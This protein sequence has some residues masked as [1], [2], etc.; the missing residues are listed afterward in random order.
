M[1]GVTEEGAKVT[2]VYRQ[3][4]DGS[5][6]FS[7]AT[8][9]LKNASD[10]IK[11]LKTQYSIIATAQ[12]E[13]VTALKSGNETLQANYKRDIDAANEKVDAIK[14]EAQAAKLSQEAQENIHRMSLQAIDSELKFRDAVQATT[15]AIQKKN[16]A[17]AQKNQN[18]LD[19]HYIKE[20][21]DAYK[22]LSTAQSEYEKAAASK[23]SS[24]MSYWKEEADKARQVADQ[25][26]R[27]A[28]ATNLSAAAKEKIR[29]I[30][31]DLNAKAEEHR[32]K[33]QDIH[34]QLE[35]NAVSLTKQVER[36]LATMVIMRGLK[37]IWNDAVKY[38]RTY[39]DQ[40]NEIRIVT[41]MNQDEADELGDSYR[42]LAQEMS[43]TSTEV[44]KAAVEFW[45]QG[46][47]KQQV[48]ER[49][50]YTTV[51][52]KISALDFETAAE[53]MTAATNSMGMSADRVADVWAYLGDAS[54]SGADE[55]GTAMQKVSAS[56]QEAGISFEWLGAY[57]A[58]LSEKTR[59]AP[60]VIGTALNSM[61]SRLQQ[62]KQKGYN[63][64]DD[65]G[66][67]DISKA[68]KTIKVELM[69]DGEWRSVSDVLDDIAAKWG[70]L[71]DKTK[72]YI[73]TVMGGT[74]QRNYLL[75][76][77]NDMSKGAENGSRA[78]ELYAGAQEAAGVAMEKYAIWEESVEAAQNRLTAA[79]EQLYS[80]LSGEMIKGWYDTLAWIINGINTASEA[81]DGWN[82]K[83]ALLGGALALLVL[84]IKKVTAATGAATFSA[85]T[86][87]YVMTGITT[88]ATGAT[89]ATNMLGVA[90]RS[91][92]I[93]IAIAAVGQLVGWF[94]S[95]KEAA[96]D[97]G[98]TVKESL[99]KIDQ[100]FSNIQTMEEFRSKL[101]E[102]DTSTNATKEDVDK[103]N[104]VRQEMISS[105]P[106]MKSALGEEVSS[107]EDLGGAYK[108]AREELEKLQK[109]QADET[110]RTA[111]AGMKS[112]RDLY[113]E[114]GGKYEGESFQDRWGG[115]RRTARQLFSTGT[116]TLGNFDYY[117][118][119]GQENRGALNL[120]TVKDYEEF[121]ELANLNIDNMRTY[122]S[123]V[124]E[125][126]G[127]NAETSADYIS[128]INDKLS[129]GE[130]MNGVDVNEALKYAEAMQKWEE[131]LW[132]V[133]MPGSESVKNEIA[134]SVSEFVQTTMT[135]ALDP[136][137]YPDMVGMFSELVGD[138]IDSTDWADA[139]YGK[140][141]DDAEAYV[142]DYVK[143]Y[144]DAIDK[145]RSNVTRYTG[146]YDNPNPEAT[147][148][149]LKE[150]AQKAYDGLMQGAIDSGIGE[151]VALRLLAPFVN[152][153]GGE[154]AKEVKNVVDTGTG[155]VVADEETE[156]DFEQNI[157]TAKDYLDQVYA[158]RDAIA[159]LQS[160]SSMT[161]T[162][163]LE[164]LY[165][166]F[167]KEDVDSW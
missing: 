38:A 123:N 79:T 99:N 6:A 135:D 27:E 72:S 98:E 104:Q 69:D 19:S 144:M 156:S 107:V 111:R 90:L 153:V 138:M 118:G 150:W 121:I 151:S 63:S 13:Y 128:Q 58:T 51:Y 14:K 31:G 82:I 49:L 75:T 142:R 73:A 53:L 41:K 54:A 28:D 136:A 48:E 131:V 65:Y 165:K 74:R 167:G 61:I 59:Q 158:L 35:D 29:T 147:P 96:V 34:A 119:D 12:K 43:V 66:L 23:D 57:I 3:M 164:S 116:Y 130:S 134:E 160:D 159:K 9:S 146:I 45:R 127:L 5:T 140:N 157:K 60:E 15:K 162:S 126:L 1:K 42:R 84:S 64:D 132:G 70:T 20:M 125:K 83:M 163:I 148:E 92:G 109:E 120:R 24:R 8:Y 113:E 25:W 33:M 88:S 105:F 124:G 133:L 71:D 100:G 161:D 141:T 101:D 52:A 26:K 18:E 16:A 139:L 67:N 108:T 110:W 129:R 166:V 11:E 76:L 46:L 39:Y 86:W 91:I 143:N 103:F 56:A 94:M 106:S 89:V 154:F 93:G 10:Y 55:I 149:S 95:M 30:Y 112:A 22:R 68:L 114:A 36:W 37:E 44:A 117:F 115:A 97:A 85:K 145:V 7:K 87:Q 47:N 4:K 32:S 77:L 80:V 62:I 137:K 17:A 152:H 50:R 102:I 78:W 122:L 40:M 155:G 81:T 2:A 21:T